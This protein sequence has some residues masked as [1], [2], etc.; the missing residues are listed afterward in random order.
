MRRAGEGS[1]RFVHHDSTW[2]RSGSRG[3]NGALGRSWLLS[4]IRAQSFDARFPRKPRVRIPDHDPPSDKF[5]RDW[6][7]RP[8]ISFESDARAVLLTASTT[9][10]LC[11]HGGG[12]STV[13]DLGDTGVGRALSCRSS[14]ANASYNTGSGR[15][16]GAV[17]GGTGS[18]NGGESEISTLGTGG[19]GPACA[20]A[21][22][23]AG[24]P[25]ATDRCGSFDGGAFAVAWAADS[26]TASFTMKTYSP[27]LAS[28]AVVRQEAG[29][30]VLGRALGGAVILRGKHKQISPAHDVG[31]TS[32]H[33][34]GEG[35][36]TRRQ[37]EEEGPGASGHR[38]V[39][40]QL[41]EDLS[42]RSG[43]RGRES[44]R[45]SSEEP[46]RAS[47]DQEAPRRPGPASHQA[48]SQRL[49]IGTDP[50]G[51]PTHAFDGPANGKKRTSR[52]GAVREPDVAESS[53][54]RRQKPR[55]RRPPR[56]SRRRKRSGPRRSPHQK[57]TPERTI[58]EEPRRQE[59]TAT[60]RQRAKSP[61]P[62]E[63]KKKET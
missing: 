35:R 9:R 20:A 31:D 10:E 27:N 48:R 61:P 25:S 54:R 50:N 46:A 34:R 16:S 18:S 6:W 60:R 43:V 39:H 41:Y 19:R 13:R 5:T 49:G 21:A 55:R 11:S 32:S 40:G 45:G 26:R 57:T 3:L 52:R 7:N 37:G 42:R 23:R 33:Q 63:T 36:L 17:A 24:P 62:V 22:D 1:G 2:H 44:G 38:A 29:E 30:Q 28:G 47:D 59:V 12:R 51:R 4:S 53:E 56:G 8:G 15:W 58:E 14:R